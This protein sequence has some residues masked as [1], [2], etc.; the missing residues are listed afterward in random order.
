MPALFRSTSRAAGALLL[1]FLALPIAALLLHAPD[2]W[3]ALAGQGPAVSRALGLSLTTSVLATALV[4]LLGTPLAYRLAFAPGR[5]LRACAPLIDLPMVL[6]PTVAGLGLLLAFGRHGLVPLGL[7]FT[8]LAVI[9]AQAFVAAP[10]YVNAAR[11]AFR[12][13]DPGLLE[14]AATLG[15]D[16]SRRFWRVLLP[17]AAPA[18]RAGALLALARALGEFGATIMFAGNREG[19]TRT[20]PLAVYGALQSDPDVAVVLSLVLLLFAALL[21]F[22]LRR[23]GPHPE[24]PRDA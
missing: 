18:L 13:V 3:P 21:L 2:S 7:P 12:G 23:M 17:V 9:L 10:F 1:A 5:L 4:V 11:V 20:L 15:A 22:I 14:A 6:P 8:T 16:E 24:E 19:V